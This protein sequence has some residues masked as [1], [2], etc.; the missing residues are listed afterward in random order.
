VAPRYRLS[1]LVQGTV[2]VQVVTLDFS[3]MLTE[4]EAIDRAKPADLKPL[5]NTNEH[6]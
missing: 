2:F 1:G 5:M 6:Q 3:E 4:A